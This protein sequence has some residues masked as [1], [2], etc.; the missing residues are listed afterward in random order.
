MVE[1]ADR[2]VV[3]C[4]EFNTC[5]VTHACDPA[6]GIGT[7]DD[8][9]ELSH[10]LEAAQRFDIHLEGTR[11]RHRWLVEHAGCDLDI[12]GTK[13][14]YHFAGRKSA[15]SDAIGIQPDP[16]GIVTR[17]DHSNVTHP[18]EAR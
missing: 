4:A 11:F 13:R 8:I 17:A 2:R 3:L 12:L 16:H 1:V 10:G 5:N 14:L 18:V 6:A 9:C 15:R 7:D